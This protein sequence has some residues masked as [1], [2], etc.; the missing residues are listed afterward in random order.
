[1]RGGGVESFT[2]HSMYLQLL[3]VV[4]KDMTDYFVM[5]YLSVGCLLE[6]GCSVIDGGIF[7][8]G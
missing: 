4:M 2:L 6:S 7:D 5:V 1:M 3:N 8:P